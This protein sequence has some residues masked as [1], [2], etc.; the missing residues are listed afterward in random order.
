MLQPSHENDRFLGFL[1]ASAMP[2]CLAHREVLRQLSCCVQVSGVFRTGSVASSGLSC[3][4]SPLGSF[5]SSP[6]GAMFFF[7]DR[8]RVKGVWR[9]LAWALCALVGITFSIEAAPVAAATP[10]KPATGEPNKPS[11]VSSRPDE[12]SAAI[13]ARAQGSPVEVE[14]LRTE[15]SQTFTNPDGTMTTKATAAPTR[16]KDDKGQ[17]RNIDLTLAEAPDGTV[18]PKSVK[19]EV[20]L[21]A[22]GCFGH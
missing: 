20:T 19:N 3:R 12:T 1:R 17:W 16:F 22:G 18:A 9:W 7:L 4:F 10:A 13:S 14:S 21:G 2:R 11:K 5:V 8:D 6:R 15:T